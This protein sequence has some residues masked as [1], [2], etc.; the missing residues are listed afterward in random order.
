MDYIEKSLNFTEILWTFAKKISILLICAFIEKNREHEYIIAALN[1]TII[2]FDDAGEIDESG[3]RDTERCI[4]WN[5]N[6]YGTGRSDRN[7]FFW[8]CFCIY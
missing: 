8:R 6:L 3:E 5:F 4:Y 1:E 2:R 7:L